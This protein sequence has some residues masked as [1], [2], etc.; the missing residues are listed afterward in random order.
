MKTIPII[1]SLFAACSVV[2]ETQQGPIVI[3]NAYLR[4][5]ISPEGK[6]LGFL[7]LTAGID[8]LQRDRQSVCSRIRCNGTEYPAT[9]A[10][11]ENDCLTIVFDRANVTAALRV[12]SLDSYIRL[13]VESLS[14]D[15]I[16]SLV[17]LNVPLTLQAHPTESFGSCA[18]SLNL[19]TRVNQ[20]P[21]LQ[22]NLQASCYDKFGIEGAKVAIV[23]MPM[24]KM[25]TALKQVLTEADEMPHCIVAGPWA[26]D[27]PFNHGSYLFNFGS[28]TESNVDEWISM[29]KNLGVNQIDNHGGKAFFRFGDFVLD[30]K[31]WPEG[32]DTY[33]HIVKRLHDAGI[34]S[35]FHTYAFFIDKQSKYITPVPDKR[36]DAFRTFTLTESIESN[37]TEI[38]VNES[39]SGMNTVTGFFEHNSVIL[40]IDDELITFDA[41]SQ[42]PPWQ[43]TKVQRGAFGTKPAAHQKGAKARHLKECFGLLVPDPESSLFEEIAKNHADIVNSC[44]FDGIYLDAIDGSSILRGADECWYWAD[45]FVFDIQKHLK[46]PVGMEMSAMWHHFW[47]FR[48][49]WQ[50]WDYPQRGHKRFVDIHAASV[51]GGLLLPLHLGWWNFQNFNPPQVEPTYPDVI[52]Y[53]GAK[54]IGWDAGISLTGSIDRDRLNSVPLFR[55]AVDIL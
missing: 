21:A 48:T 32:W 28:L 20:L 18:L 9:S 26:H 4:Y 52:E 47:Q 8:Y 41:V 42:E 36:L 40:H 27:V 49:R 30:S 53:L 22:T 16:E 43:F 11:L 6:N 46:K 25:L 45:K 34:G 50:A 55:R 33:R 31:K 10:R 39:T 17:F 7:D 37:G 14:G 29:A 35:I 19:I 24:D 51:N 13:T 54:L 1:L 38:I 12:E 15:N 23:A 3:E 2:N 44:D 5:T